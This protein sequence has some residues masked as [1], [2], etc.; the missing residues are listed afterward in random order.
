MSKDQDQG[1]NPA[2][3]LVDEIAKRFNEQIKQLD[4]IPEQ[5][6]TAVDAMLKIFKDDK[7]DIFAHPQTFYD[8]LNKLS[9]IEGYANHTVLEIEL[10]RERVK[11]PT[12]FF[13]VFSKQR[14]K[15]EQSKTLNP[16]IVNTAEPVKN[17]PGFWG[18]M[19]ERERTRVLSEHLKSSEMS[20]TITTTQKPGDILDYARD[21]TREYNKIV[22][23]FRACLAHIKVFPHEEGTRDLFFAEIQSYMVKLCNIMKSFSRAIAE[24]RKELVGQREEA[25]ATALTLMKKAEYESLGGMRTADFYRMM[26]EGMGGQD[27]SER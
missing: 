18:Y 20:P 12:A 1:I 8:C 13:D 6:K 27:L 4:K 5:A 25:Y 9:D 2:E 26:R 19:S 11:A 21:I 3:E 15:E 10:I 23:Y 24:Y 16:V 17:S 22:D 14:A 7:T